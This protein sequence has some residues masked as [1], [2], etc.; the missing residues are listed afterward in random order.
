MIRYVYNQ[1]TAI[2]VVGWQGKSLTQGREMTRL[3]FQPFEQRMIRLLEKLRATKSGRFLFESLVRTGRMVRIHSGDDYDDNACKMDPNIATGGPV[4]EIKPFRPAHHNVP[5]AL[6]GSEQA[7]RGLDANDNRTAQKQNIKNQMVGLG[8]AV[9]KEET[10]PV[11]QA[12]LNRTHLGMTLDPAITQ[13]RFMRPHVEL[14]QRLNI[15]STDFDNMLHGLMYMPDDVYYPLCFLLYD[16]ATPGGGTNAQVRVMNQMTFDHDFANDVRDE[17]K[18]LRSTQE[19]ATRLDAV[20]L[21][22]E[23]IHAW[24]I[25][26]GRR[27]VAGGWEEEAMTSGIGPFSRWKLTENALRSD[28][29]LTQRKLYANPSHSSQ[30]MAN[31]HNSMGNRSYRGIM[32]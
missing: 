20:I 8:R 32:F 2:Q 22:H 18:V 24:R 10:A 29:S 30:L 21:G 16:Y 23:L 11:L 6:K 5:L 15:S 27:V 9:S 7:W 26:A 31:I 13:S 28:L 4:A 17:G 25:M 1:C 19:T 14:P 3:E 12:M